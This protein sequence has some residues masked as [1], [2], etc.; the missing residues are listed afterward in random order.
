MNARGEFSTLI[1]QNSFDSP[2]LSRVG[3]AP[4]T[5][6]QFVLAHTDHGYASEIIQNISH[7]FLFRSARQ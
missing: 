3:L 1:S 7:G 2:L 4:T 6:R 5:S